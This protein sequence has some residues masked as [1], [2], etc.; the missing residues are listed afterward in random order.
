[1]RYPLLHLSTMCG[2]THPRESIKWVLSHVD[3]IDVNAKTGKLEYTALHNLI[4]ISYD[5][6]DVIGSTKLLLNKGADPL[7]KDA[8]GKTVLS[9]ALSRN[10]SEL[11]NLLTRGTKPGVKSKRRRSRKI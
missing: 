1:M 4:I 7:A 9:Y 2:A 3:T 6:D 8:E 5:E 10:N 11:S